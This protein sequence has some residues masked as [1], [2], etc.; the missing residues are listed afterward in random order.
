MTSLTDTIQHAILSCLPE[1]S[2]ALVR[3]P[4]NDGQHFEAAVMSPIFEGM[5]LVKQH[6]LVMKALK[7]AFETS[8]HA[9]ALKTYTPQQWPY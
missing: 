1:G 6:Q 3:N 9:L 7:S 4:H 2:Q 8:V 5:P